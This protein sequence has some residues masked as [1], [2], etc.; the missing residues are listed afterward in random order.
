MRIL[1]VDTSSK[2]RIG[3]KKDEDIFEISYV[4]ARKH[5]EIL[6][7]LIKEILERNELSVKDLDVVGVGIG[8][9]GLTG[10]RVG[11]AT[12]IGMVAPFRIPVAP[13]V[14]FEMAA[15]SCPSDGVILVAK[16]ARK[17]Y[18]YCAVYS[19]EDDKLDIIKEPSVLADKEMEIVVSEIKPSIFIKDDV[20]ISPRTLVEESERMLKEKKIIQH[21]EVEPL[22][23]QKSI[24]ELNFEK[25]KGG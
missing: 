11:I 8:P 2:I 12:I 17:G 15:K 4:G 25:R 1:A 19:K 7:V 6:H 22:Y 20:F 23:L 24:A 5:A 9:G 13:L 3:L 16:K 18:S 10:L 21:D 14:S